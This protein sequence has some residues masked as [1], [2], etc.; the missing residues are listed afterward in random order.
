VTPLPR[1]PSWASWL[2]A[3]LGFAFLV[4]KARVL[5]S[6]ETFWVR[7]SGDVL[8]LFA[9]VTFAIAGL[10]EAARWWQARVWRRQTAFI[11]FGLMQQAVNDLARIAWRAFGIIEPAAAEGDREQQARVARTF[12]LSSTERSGQTYQELYKAANRITEALRHDEMSADGRRALL[13]GARLVVPELAQ[14]VERA[15]S[16]LTQLSGYLHKEAKEIIEGSTE[17]VV[18]AG[19]LRDMVG[20]IG[21]PDPKERAERI[22]VQAFVVMHKSHELVSSLTNGFIDV[23]RLVAP[24]GGPG[25]IVPSLNVSAAL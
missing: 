11:V 6:P 23:W 17:L 3:G 19:E 2:A 21:S 13:T 1:V 5:G 16:V 4:L 10:S 18:Q 9:G 20:D 22:D 12:S 7:L 14:R 8:G 25:A 24:D 15:S